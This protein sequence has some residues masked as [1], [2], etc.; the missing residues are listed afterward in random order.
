[1]TTSRVRATVDELDYIA[2]ACAGSRAAASIITA[3][4]APE[5]LIRLFDGKGKTL[6]AEYRLVHHVVESL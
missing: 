1:M 4:V 5:S 2:D 6:L 3:E